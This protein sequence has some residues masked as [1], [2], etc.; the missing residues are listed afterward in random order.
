MVVYT[1]IYW[2]I[3]NDPFLYYSL[4]LDS[5]CRAAAFKFPDSESAALSD[6]ESPDGGGVGLA[7]HGVKACMGRRV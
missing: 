6:S 3:P 4:V 1:G 7:R 5:R 2:Y